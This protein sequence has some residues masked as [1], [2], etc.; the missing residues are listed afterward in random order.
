VDQHF[1]TLVN[2]RIRSYFKAEL[3]DSFDGRAAS[4]L[5]DAGAI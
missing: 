4:N 1:S 5:T 3:S 2:R